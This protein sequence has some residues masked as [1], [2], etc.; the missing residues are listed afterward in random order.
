MKAKIVSTTVCIL[1]YGGIPYFLQKRKVVLREF[2]LRG[3]YR[4]VKIL[5]PMNN[6]V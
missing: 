3:W 1:R 6:L 5:V 2:S 4:N